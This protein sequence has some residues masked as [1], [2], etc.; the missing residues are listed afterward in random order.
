MAKLLSA[1]S[2]SSVHP[3]QGSEACQVCGQEDHTAIQCSIFSNQQDTAEVNYARNQG[4]Y[5][6]GYNTQWM[7]HPNL[8][9]RNNQ[10]QQQYQVNQ[11]N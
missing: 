5:S 4:P 6:F 11:N 9:Y 3:I 1:S 8:S 7:N 10:Q 2:S